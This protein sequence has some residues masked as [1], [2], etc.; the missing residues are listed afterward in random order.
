MVRADLTV[1]VGRFQPLH[2]GHLTV[3]EEALQRSKYLLILV[4]S[5]NEPRSYRNPFTVDE[6]IEMIAS[7]LTAEQR[8]RVIFRGLEDSAY[9]LSEWV[10]SVQE[11]VEDAKEEMDDPYGDRVALI[12]HSKDATSY[13][14]KLFPQ[15]ESINVDQKQILDAT[16]IREN[17]FGFGEIPWGYVP[18]EVAK[19]LEQFIE[20]PA[21]DEVVAEYDYV[22][23]Y[24]K[25]WESAPF[26]PIFVTADACVVQSGHVLLIKRKTWP[27][28]GLWALPGGFVNQN[29]Y[30]ETGMIREL[31][32]ETG[33]KV[34]GPVLRGHIVTSKVFDA[35]FRSSRGRTITHAYL[36]HLDPNTE[37]PPV[38]GSD[39]A[40]KAQWVP[41]SDIHREMFFEDHYSILQNLTAL[42]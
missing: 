39:D 23:R 12:G 30:I 29:E 6:R 14:L 3:V 4:G 27:G 18:E 25:Q 21:Y 11:K 13:Y 17:Y 19:F 22:R 10:K 7:T 34:P 37:L 24:K 9:N 1:F 20:T 15:Y 38:K 33:L 40:E 26:P 32:E 36:I 16:T 28:K 42:L 8:D 41:L 31:R 2:Y 35:P 5:A